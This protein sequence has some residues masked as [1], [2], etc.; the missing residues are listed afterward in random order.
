MD[1]AVKEQLRRFVDLWNTTEKVVKQAELINREL[2]R[3]SINELRYAGRW[4][5][6]ALTAILKN[7]KQIDRLTTVD[8]VLSYA[9]LCCMQAKHDAIDSIVLF[10]HE[11]IDELNARYTAYVIG[12]YVQ[13]YSHFLKEVTEVDRLITT[14]RGERENRAE[15]YDHIF[16]EHLPKLMDYLQRVHDAETEINESIKKETSKQFWDKLWLII[17]LIFNV[18]FFGVVVYDHWPK[19]VPIQ[20]SIAGH[21]ANN[22]SI[23][24]KPGDAQPR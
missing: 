8:N 13:D 1:D 14:S 15:I 24:A 16:K 22:P 11:K 21:A 20:T 10:L 2:I 9:L 12:L 3:P 7:E 19:A 23:G 18:F 5:V 6:L 17:S 4:M